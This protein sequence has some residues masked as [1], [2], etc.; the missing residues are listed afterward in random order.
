MST[1]ILGVDI[2]SHQGDVN[3]QQT[4]EGGFRFCVCKATEGKDF[5]DPRFRENW[6]KLLDLDPATVAGTTMYRGAYHFARPDLRP[7][8]GRAAGELEGRW[9]AQVLKEVGSYGAG[10]LPPMLDWEK[11]GGGSSTNNREWIT[12]FLDVVVNE[13]GRVCGLYT[14][15]NV[16]YYTTDDWD[17][18]IEYALWEV[19]YTS[20]GSDPEADP[21][22]MP[23]KPGRQPWPWTIWQ[24][25][26]GGDYAYYRAEFGDVPGMPKG[27]SDVNNFN[28]TEEDLAALALMSGAPEPPCPTPD[29]EPAVQAGIMQRLNLAEFDSGTAWEIVK[30]V[31]GLLMANGQGPEGLVGSDGLPDGRCGDGTRAALRRFK[32]EHGLPEDVLVDAN[33][34]FL[35]QHG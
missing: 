19:N 10:C 2:A 5:E 8:Q 34:W 12:G 33:T 32:L 18:L 22:P 7:D 27:N 31:Q 15:P 25:S 11:Y 14:G 29:P 1:S 35:L 3:L 16:W 13:L 26:G 17:G 21:R 6:K 28:G 23:R 24:W 9:F 4:A 20:R 30:V